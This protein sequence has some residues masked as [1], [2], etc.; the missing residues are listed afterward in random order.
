MAGSPRPERW[1]WRSRRGGRILLPTTTTNN[2]NNQQPNNHN[3]QQPWATGLGQRIR[4][5]PLQLR[6][7]NLM[8]LGPLEQQGEGG[9]PSL[10]QPWV[11][12]GCHPRHLT[13][14]LHQAM[15]GRLEFATASCNCER[16]AVSSHSR[17]LEGDSPPCV[18]DLLW[19][20]WDDVGHLRAQ[21]G[22]APLVRPRSARPV[23][24]VHRLPPHSAQSVLL[25]QL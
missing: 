22:L 10:P 8:K 16:I 1:I 6:I 14:N 20:S 4:V 7:A 13:W 19:G 25:L 5:G 2:H 21:T 3:N 18:P 24:W 17:S 23:S 11:P 15:T 9:L 12:R